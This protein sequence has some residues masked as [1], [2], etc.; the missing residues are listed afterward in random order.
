MRDR[1]VWKHSK[2]HADGSYDSS[3]VYELLEAEVIEAVIK[4]RRN[5]RLKTKSE[6]GRGTIALYANGG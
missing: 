6:A 2:A 5:G 4:P 1:K 3:T